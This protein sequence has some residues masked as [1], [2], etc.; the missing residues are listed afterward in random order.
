MP[1]IEVIGALEERLPASIYWHAEW[2][3]L[4]EGKDWRKFLP[5]THIEQW[6]PVLFA[7]VY[8]SGF[9][10]AVACRGNPGAP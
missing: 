8:L 3:A 1:L 2:I 9:V 10:V 5:F 6:V 7:L 4:G